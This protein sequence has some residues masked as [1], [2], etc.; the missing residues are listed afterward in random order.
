MNIEHARCELAGR[1]CR[2]AMMLAVNE[3]IARGERPPD[4]ISAE[5][6]REGCQIEA[7]LVPELLEGA[8]FADHQLESNAAE[9]HRLRAI[10]EQENV[11]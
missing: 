7:A 5:L 11:Q 3:A 2:Q 6:E 10:V 9:I 8:R 1:E 4:E